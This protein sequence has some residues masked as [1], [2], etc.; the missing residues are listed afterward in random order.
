MYKNFHFV[1]VGN[2]HCKSLVCDDQFAVVTSFN[3]LSYKGA[4]PVRTVTE[5]FYSW[6]AEFSG[7]GQVI[8]LENERIYT[9]TADTLRPI[10]FTVVPGSGRTG[11]Y[12]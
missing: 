10:E 12:A 3:W 7:R 5:K 11:F 1:Y 6:L 2:T 9:E 8:V 4:V